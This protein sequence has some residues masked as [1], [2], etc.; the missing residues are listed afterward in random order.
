MNVNSKISVIVPVYNLENE[1]S[2]CIASIQAQTYTN[3]EIILVDDGSKDGSREVIQRLAEKDSRIVSIF[4]ENGGVTSARLTGCRV[5]T[6]DYIG[7]VDGDD[8]IEPD[9]YELLL[10]NAVKYGADISHCGYQMV[11][12]DGRIHYFHNTGCVVQQDRIK[13]MQ[14][15]L[16]GSLIEP[17]LWNKLFHK[18]LFQRMLNTEAMD[19]SI[20]INE[21]LLMNYYLFKES[22]KAVFQ[23]VCKYH[24]I[25]RYA[26][27]SRQRMN[28]NKIFDPIRVKKIILNDASDEIAEIARKAYVATCVNIY[29]ELICAGSGEYEAEKKQIRTLLLKSSEWIKN[30]NKKTKLLAHLILHIP[31]LY[32]RMYR[33]Y[34]KYLQK[35]KYD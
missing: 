33:T 1:L 9:M 24:Y 25:V 29:N 3:L 18:T 28:R 30:L 5:A 17:G 19:F 11:F 7:F 16:D 35:R 12:D 22:K 23:D 20:K 15:L 31:M 34:A 26:S 4:K 14:D 32:P 2:N 27:A 21:D 13:G 10:N 8:E 6:G